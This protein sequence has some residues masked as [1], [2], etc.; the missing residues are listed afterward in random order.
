VV[1]PERRAAKLF[2]WVIGLL[3][4]AL[5]VYGWFTPG[6]LLGTPFAIPLGVPDN[7]FHLLL[8]VPALAIVV[9]D[10]RR[11]LRATKASGR[12]THP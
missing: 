2:T 10:V 12:R 1:C 3:Y 8:G 7:V 11:A 6:L 9:L 5:G 4:F